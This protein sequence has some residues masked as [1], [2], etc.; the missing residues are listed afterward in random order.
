MTRRPAGPTPGRFGRQPRARRACGRPVRE[1]PRV[2]SVVAGGQDQPG[3]SRRRQSAASLRTGRRRSSRSRSH[4]DCSIAGTP[5]RYGGRMPSGAAR[6]RRTD[7]ERR[8]RRQHRGDATFAQ[9]VERGR[10]ARDARPWLSRSAASPPADNGPMEWLDSTTR[11]PMSAAMAMSARAL[12]RAGRSRQDKD[13][14]HRR[15]HRIRENSAVGGASPPRLED[16]PSHDRRRQLP[17]PGKRVGQIAID[18]LDHFRGFRRRLFRKTR[19]I[20]VA[21]LA[22][23]AS[24]ESSTESWST[25]PRFPFSHA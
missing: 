1:E 6:R 22:G 23:P 24:A 11:R 16:D 17:V 25:S 20:E 12:V 9:I 14:G 21:R 3:R 13:R 7:R 8:G 10:L 15:W 19:Q 2:A 4:S 18:A 5:D